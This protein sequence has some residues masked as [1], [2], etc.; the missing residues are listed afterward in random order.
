MDLYGTRLVS[1]DRVM[2]SVAP[3]GISV[4]TISDTRSLADDRSG[5][6]LVARLLAAGHR[7]VARKLVSDDIYRVR[8]ALSEWIAEEAVQ[9]VLTTGGTGLTGRDRTPEAIRPLLDADIP[10]FGERF[11]ALSFAEVG[12]SAF[13]SR[14][15]AGLAN[16]TLIFALPGSPGACA[17]AWDGVIAEQLDPENPRCNLRA[18]MPRMGET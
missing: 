17:S 16:R 3:L 18:L 1:N 8:A 13:A 10:A 6:V 9:V 15:F 5:D 7:L 12:G 11:R 14:A 4:L 2:G